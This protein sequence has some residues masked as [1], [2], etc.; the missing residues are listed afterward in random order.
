MGNYSQILPVTIKVQCKALGSYINCQTRIKAKLSPIFFLLPTNTD[1][2][3]NKE[4]ISWG[5]VLISKL[6]CNG[7]LIIKKSGMMQPK[8]SYFSMTANLAIFFNAQQFP[9]AFKKKK[10]NTSYYLLVV[11]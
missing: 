1:T 6:C 5:V 4:L 8:V 9:V 7:K 2:L 11:I 10:N 3:S